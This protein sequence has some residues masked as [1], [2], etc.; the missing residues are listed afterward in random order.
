MTAI[1]FTLNCLLVFL[2]LAAMM[3]GLRLEKRLRGLRDSHKGFAQAALDLNAAI[4]RAE[5]GLG[6]MRK[7]LH[8]AEETL[9]E[10]VDEARAAARKLEAA[11]QKAQA[12]PQ[13]PAARG[14]PAARLRS[15]SA[16]TDD[17][18]GLPI[19][20]LLAR[21]RSSLPLE[22]RGEARVLELRDRVAPPSSA[23]SRARVDDDLFDLDLPRRAGAAR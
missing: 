9:T 20:D 12:V 15:E 17:L 14:E 21:L 1:A 7:A 2:L 10:R 4:A 23:R 22:D 13:P 16:R 8:E 11:M 3:V 18:D 5:N 19:K 6:D